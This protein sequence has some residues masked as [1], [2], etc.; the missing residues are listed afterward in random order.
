MARKFSELY[1]KMPA[2][3]RAKVEARV[4]RTLELMTLHELR[5]ERRM[6]QVALAEGLGSTQSE[7]SKIENRADMKIGTLHDYV[8]ALGGTLEIRAVFPEKTVDL[9]LGP[10]GQ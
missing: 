2:E 5:R 3:A 1:N 10:R 8:K 7:V 4:Q 6:S 9:V